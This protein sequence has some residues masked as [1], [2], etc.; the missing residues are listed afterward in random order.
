[1]EESHMF[2]RQLAYVAYTVAALALGIGTASAQD[3]LQNTGGGPARNF[4][5][6]DQLA[7]SS[8][9]ALEIREVAV[10]N[11]PDYGTIHFAPAVDYFIVKNLSIGGFVGIDYSRAGDADGFRFSIGPRVGYNLSFTNLLGLWPKIGFTYAH[12]NSGYSRA[13]A[14]GTVSTSDSNDAIAINVFV[15][16]M[17]HPTTH[18]FVGFGPFVDADLNGDYRTVAYGMKLTIGG[19][20]DV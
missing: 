10:E 4:G 2:T 8:E 7:F 15:P 12:S 18:F 17:F 11:G 6:I 13:F 1:M 9:N 5:E 3:P 20:L 14:G 16:V 19:W